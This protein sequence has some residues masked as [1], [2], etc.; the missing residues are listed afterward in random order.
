MKKCCRCKIDKSLDDYHINRKMKDG[1]SATCKACMKIS[2]SIAEAKKRSTPE[3]IEKERL[4][5]KERYHRLYKKNPEYRVGCNFKTT[6]EVD[7]YKKIDGLSKSQ[8]YKLKF[9]EKFAC[10]NIL[11]NSFFKKGIERHHWSYN[12]EHACD[13]IPLDTNSHKNLHKHLMYDQE[14]FMYRRI[15]TMELLDTREKHVE[16][17]N[18]LT[19]KI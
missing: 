4:R 8:V 11:G 6:H 10:K 2:S 17:Y 14:R 19:L 16:F 12:I 13:I 7:N 5:S 3:G 18:S 9:P 15:D 1:K